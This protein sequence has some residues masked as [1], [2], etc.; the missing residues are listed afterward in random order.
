MINAAGGM[1]GLTEAQMV[2]ANV[3]LVELLDAVRAL[4]DPVRV[5]QLGSVHEYGL[6]PVGTSMTEDYAPEPVMPYGKLKLEC[7]NLVLDAARRGDVEGV[8]LRV[9]NVVG[10][11]PAR[12]QPAR[13]W[14]RPAAR[15]PRP[16]RARTGAGP[17]GS[18]RDFVRPQPTRPRP[19]AAATPSRPPFGHVINIGPGGAPAR[20]AGPDCS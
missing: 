9:G 16:G 17:L 19:S 18:Q 13:A 8:V 3:T 1:W 4:P 11:R 14:W 15:S 12:A 7:A 20:G 2:E 5:I 10:A 6:A